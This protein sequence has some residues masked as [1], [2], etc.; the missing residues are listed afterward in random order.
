MADNDEEEEQ[1]KPATFLPPNSSIT[2]KRTQIPPLSDQLQL[3]H[4]S[5]PPLSSS[6]P[7]GDGDDHWI[8]PPNNHEGL[9]LLHHHND[10]DD[11]G[12][13]RKEERS[14][15]LSPVSGELKPESM[16]AVKSLRWVSGGV[17]SWIWRFSV[18]RGGLIRLFN[19]PMVGFGSMM[20]LVVLFHLRFRRRRRFRREAV[21]ELLGVI[22]EKDERMRQLLYQIAR[23]N[24]LL[25]VTHHGVPITSKAE[26]S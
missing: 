6:D 19:F 20:V 7:N 16:G 1:P 8:F 24:E 26:S 11:R 18:I 25:L 15:S 2:W 23:M 13:T 21:D 22:K 3:H 4:Q 17:F 10:D 14:T 12:E 9:K 5:K